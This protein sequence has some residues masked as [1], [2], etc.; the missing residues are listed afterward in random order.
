MSDRLSRIVGELSD[1]CQSLMGPK[2]AFLGAQVGVPQRNIDVFVDEVLRGTSL[3]AVSLA[4]QRLEPVLR[5]LA[6]LPPWQL[7]STVDKP[8]RGELQLIDKMMHIQDKVFK[9]PTILLSG[10]VSGEEE[11]PEGV[12]AVLVRSA[13]EAP[14]ILSHCAVR[15]RNSKVLLATCFD[16]AIS[17]QLAKDFEGKWVEVRCTPD[18]H[19]H[20]EASKPPSGTPTSQ[21]SDPDATEADMKASADKK[22]Q[23]NLTDDLSCAWC[24]RPDEMTR[25]RVGSKSL[26]LA[27]LHPRLPAGVLTPQAVALPYGCMQKALTDAANATTVLPKLQEV[28]GRLQPSTSNEDAQVVF[29]EA[30]QLVM[31]MVMPEDLKGSLQGAM[32]QEGAKQGEERLKE[33]FDPRDAW[34]AIKGVWASLFALRPWISLAK[35]GRSFH[36]LNMAVLVQE[37][38]EAKYAF[39]LHTVNPFTHDKDELYGELF[40]GRGEA[41]VGNYPGRAL[42]FK[43]RRGGEVEVIAFPSKSV[44]LH[45]QHCLIFRSDSNGE[46]L[47]GFAGAGLFESIC[48]QSDAVG[49]V[50]LHRLPVVTDRGYRQDLLKRIAE[51]GWATETAFGGAPQDIEGCVDV[52]DR[53]FVV[54]SRPQV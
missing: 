22:V 17:A 8:V 12:L 35:A 46:D 30:Q 20:V 42:S 23:M 13:K 47:E 16:P 3:I 34:A 52:G 28:L 38:V 11:V 14:D 31:R 7:I 50:R 4:L 29:E 43:V 24:V 49:F 2:A 26:N 53:I 6:Q 44:A 1:R 21:K 19:L 41:I 40:A 36:D 10:A 5:G 25:E 33:L 48:A 18:G 37:L 32:A 51:V 15:A 39:V 27:L 9:T 54:Q 45:T